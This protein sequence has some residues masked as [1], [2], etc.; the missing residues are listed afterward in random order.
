M[1]SNVRVAVKCRPLNSKEISLNCEEVVEFHE[2][3][4]LIKNPE[5]SH[6]VFIIFYYFFVIFHSVFFCFFCFFEIFTNL[7]KINIIIYN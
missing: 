2:N 1:A 4:I 7:L 5:D 3:T 6:Q